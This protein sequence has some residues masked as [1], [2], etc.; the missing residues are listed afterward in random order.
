[1]G[2]S[3]RVGWCASLTDRGATITIVAIWRDGVDRGGL[4][5]LVLSHCLQPIHQ[6]AVGL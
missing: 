2:L 5:G 1:M 4:F 6:I 3:F